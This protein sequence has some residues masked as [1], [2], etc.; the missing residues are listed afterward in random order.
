MKIR[1]FCLPTSVHGRL[2]CSLYVWGALLVSYKLVSCLNTTRAEFLNVRVLLADPAVFR[3]QVKPAQRTRVVS[4]DIFRAPAR[5]RLHNL[6]VW[7][8]CQKASV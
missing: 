2:V 1:Q 4:R 5:K 6:V 3:T 7:K 8:I